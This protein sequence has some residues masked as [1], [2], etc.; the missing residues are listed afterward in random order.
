MNE[1][2]RCKERRKPL[3]HEIN[4]IVCGVVRYYVR[5]GL[6]LAD[7]DGNIVKIAYGV[8][9]LKLIRLFDDQNSGNS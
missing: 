8:R 2:L 6:P 1:Y 5:V 4:Q 7:T 3:Y 9:L